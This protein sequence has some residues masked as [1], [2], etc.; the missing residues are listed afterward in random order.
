[1]IDF[2][3]LKRLLLAVSFSGTF[4]LCASAQDAGATA[5]ATT[6]PTLEPVPA[7][8]T[9]SGNQPSGLLTPPPD[10]APV[11]TTT[12]APAPTD[13]TT[14]TTTTTTTAKTPAV[15]SPSR[16]MSRSEISRI[17]Q[18]EI[19]RRQ[20]LVYRADQALSAG[21]RAE[22]ATDY[23]TARQ[24][25][26]FAVEAYGSISRATASYAQAAEGLTRVDFAL[27][28]ASLRIGDTVRAKQLIDEVIKY[29]PNNKV[30]QQKL[31][32]TDRAL[33]NPNDT[34]LLGNPA[35]T[36]GF[37]D[38]VNEVQKLFVEAEQFRRTGQWDEADA[39]LKR[40][41][42]IDPYNISATKQLE[43]IDAEKNKYADTARLE[44]RDE[45]LRQVEEKWAEPINNIEAGAE[46][47]EAQPTLTRSTSFNTEQI[48]DSVFLSLDFNNASIEEA[49]NFLSIES[50][51]LDPTHKGVNFIIQ[52][53]ASATAKPITLT[54]NHVPLSDALRYVCQL[55]NVK[56]KV[57]DYAISIVPFTQNTDDLISRTFT[58][59][60]SFVAP[61]SGSTAI[62]SASSAFFARRPINPNLAPA[63]GASAGGDTVRAALEAKGVKFAPGGSAVYTA[64]TG[65]LTVVDTAD[66]M[67]LLEE[68]VNAG[69]APT[70]MVRI[71][72]KFVEINQT[73]L[74]DL[75]VN[76]AFNF[77]ANGVSTPGV[78]QT[79][80]LSGSSLAT[81]LAGSRGI[82][83]DSIDALITP[84]TGGFNTFNFSG[85][86]SG[87]QYNI[88][89]NALSQKKSA[90]LLNDPAV[91]VKSGEQGTLEAVRVFPYPIAFDPPE[92]ISES[93]T[94]TIGTTPI[95]NPPVV[96]AT[97]PTDFKRRNVGTRLVVKPQVA[98]DNQTVDLSLFPEVTQ[99]DGF[100]NYGS[101]INIGNPDGSTS[102][103][104][105]NELNQPVFDTRRINTK[106]LIHD[107]STVV[108][109]GLIREDLQTVNDRVPILG[110][111]PLI[112]RLFQ[113]K[114]T[115]SIKR[116]LII[117]VTANIYRNDGELL[118]PPEVA[119]A[120]DI[121]TGR[122][123]IGTAPTP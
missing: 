77:F 115:E 114:A 118:N 41:L 20:E 62:N 17:Q 99:F 78:E 38:R 105:T 44:T 69:Q 22:L 28:D 85:F 87:F 112:G 63:A 108:L 11:V 43:R 101:V 104:S 65:Q 64:T 49:T 120:A 51:R 26:L 61:P 9:P 73:D 60:P 111:I 14:S 53:N 30:A 80:V 56:F 36:P 57:Q 121:L 86:L 100:I 37:V 113:S 67:E 16:R 79:K 45:R 97:T 6:P 13:T 93:N 117:F 96:I 23:P 72:T 54:L 90:D 89:L 81:S 52:P 94:T 18:Q 31:L 42:G 106:V 27:Y 39:R 66:Q 82:S 47:Q 40:I 98:S 84:T 122:A 4:S 76:T 32:A 109:G 59:E 70:L 5:P 21:A 8:P 58:V 7:P 2:A 1:M 95:V 48:M 102:L 46:A 116:N 75:T 119:N 83:P 91:L 55:A 29:N 12:P 68:L 74:N 92:L 25:Y 3:S 110:D 15:F 10:V 88:I 50:K 103:L 123:N 35:I 33:A 19:I 24:N 107:G 34:S 71:A